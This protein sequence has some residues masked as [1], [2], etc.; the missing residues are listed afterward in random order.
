MSATTTIHATPIPRADAPRDA[1]VRPGLFPFAQSHAAALSPLFWCLQLYVFLTVSALDEHFEQT[2]RSVLPGALSDLGPRMIIG[3]LTLAMAVGQMI[4]RRAEL[5]EAAHLR[6]TLWL[7][8]FVMAGVFATLWAYVPGFASDAFIS[9]FTSML[10]FALILVIVRTRRELVLTLLT[11]C[12]A[13]GVYLA[14]SWWEWRGGRYEYAQGVVRMVGAGSAYSDPNSFAATI[15]FAVPLMIWMLVHARPAWIK[16]GAVAYIGLAL[17]AVL[18]TSSRSG[19][20]LMCMACGWAILFLPRGRMKS[21]A[22]VLAIVAVVAL[23]ALLSRS[24]VQRI[25]TIFSGNTYAKEEST[26]GRVEGYVVA[27]KMFQSHPVLGVGPGNWS[28][29]RQGKIDGNPLMP[30][31]MVGQLIG[32]RGAAGALTFFAF[33]AATIGLGWGTYRRRKREGGAW[34]SAVSRLCA[35][36]LMTY[37][38]LFVSGLGAHNLTRPNWYWCSALMLV[39]ITCRRERGDEDA[40]QEGAAR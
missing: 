7:G 32:T 29:Y 26:H 9:H 18:N 38:L 3:S 30:H 12:F 11:F 20:I 6:P 4:T 14:L 17:L 33:L 16:V 19:L 25:E 36:M 23:P 39:A 31:N 21:G 1:L 34:N 13:I 5:P 8:G 35:A 40:L 2:I 22:L 28:P 15:V 10:S 24:Q 27:W 37:A